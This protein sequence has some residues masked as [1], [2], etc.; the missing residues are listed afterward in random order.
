MFIPN[1]AKHSFAVVIPGGHHEQSGRPNGNPGSSSEN[2]AIL[3]NQV[4]K[5]NENRKVNRAFCSQSLW[6]VLV[7]S[8]ASETAGAPRNSSDLLPCYMVRSTLLCRRIIVG[9][10]KFLKISDF[11]FENEILD[12]FLC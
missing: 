1:G 10:R 9:H 5:W 2:G 4:T 6:K 7:V 3:M 11:G 8:R 12:Y